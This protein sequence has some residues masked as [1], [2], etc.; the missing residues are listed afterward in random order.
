M[1]RRAM[2]RSSTARFERVHTSI[3]VPLARSGLPPIPWQAGPLPTKWR[4]G[5]PKE[6]SGSLSG[7]LAYVEPWVRPLLYDRFPQNLR[8]HVLVTMPLPAGIPGT[9]EAIEIVESVVHEPLPTAILVLH[10]AIHAADA[11][12]LRGALDRFTNH[13][14]RHRNSIRGWIGDLVLPWAEIHDSHR[15]AMHV[16][17]ATRAGKDW[18]PQARGEETGGPSDNELLSL[19]ANSGRYSQDPDWNP[20]GADE[21]QGFRLIRMS[22]NLRGLASRDG[23]SLVGLKPDDGG[24]G[25]ANGFDYD[26]AEFFAKGLYVDALLV[27]TQ[28]RLALDAIEQDFRDARGHPSSD[29]ISTLESEIDHFRT[30]IW[31]TAFAPQGSQTDVLRSLQ[32]ICGLVAREGRLSGGLEEFAARVRRDQQEQ[33]AAIIRAVTLIGLPSTI[34]WNLLVDQQVAWRAYFLYA[35]LV[36]FFASAFRPGIRAA[37]GLTRHRPTKR[38]LVEWR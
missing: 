37:L 27:F 21:R 9:L 3:L 6:V 25:G 29:A 31:G 16:T 23:F 13:N 2:Q 22:D 14:V 35:M 17:L 36:F 10:A 19:I 26:G 20:V 15:R 34:I 11:A 12:E 7:R 28:Q 33:I 38:H 1:W 8:W 32:E 30:A 24:S 18:P 5:S 4:A